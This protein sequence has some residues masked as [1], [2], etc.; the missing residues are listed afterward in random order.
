MSTIQGNQR[1]AL[2]KLAWSQLK[3]PPTVKRGVTAELDGFILA[4]N[5]LN[6][7]DLIV[8]YISEAPAEKNLSQLMQ[9]EMLYLFF[10]E[11]ECGL[12]FDDEDDIW[13]I[14]DN[15]WKPS[16]NLT[17]VKSMVL[18]NFLSVMKLIVAHVK[19]VRLFPPNAEGADHPRLAFL[20]KT[21]AALENRDSIEKIIKES[22][23]FMLREAVFDTNA[24]LFQ[25]QN[26]VL[27][28]ATNT[29][30]RGRPSD[31]SQRA[32]PITV[33]D[34]WL[35][36]PVLFVSE[37]EHQRQDAWNVMWSM[38]ERDGPYHVDD[39][40]DILGDQDSVNFYYLMN[41]HA[42]WLEGRP[43]GKCALFYS[44]R[45]RNS[46]GVNE[47]IISSLWG[48][49]Y[50]PVRPTIFIADRRNE[51]EHTAAELN[52]RGARL[53]WFNETLN[54]PWSNGVF[55]NKNSSDPVVCRGCGAG[56][57]VRYLPTYSFGGGINDPPTWEKKPKGS[58]DDRVMPLYMPNKYL[59]DGES[60]ESPRS[61]KKDVTLEAKVCSEDFALGHLLNLIQIRL[62]AKEDGISLDDIIAQGTP[63]SKHWRQLWMSAWQS[64]NAGLDQNGYSL[65]D[66]VDYHSR[67]YHE[68][69]FQ[70]LEW[71]VAKDKNFDGRAV[72]K[73]GKVLQMINNAGVIGQMLMKVTTSLSRKNVEQKALK[74]ARFDYH[75]YDA[76][77][78]QEFFGDLSRY[79]YPVIDVP[80]MFE[81]AEV[82]LGDLNTVPVV[83]E[84]LGSVGEGLEQAL[85]I[86]N[87]CA[88]EARSVQ[89][90]S[91]SG[92]RNPRSLANAIFL[93]RK[94]GYPV[95]VGGGCITECRESG[96]WAIQR[97][98]MQSDGF[99]LLYQIGAGIQNITRESRS[100]MLEGLCA[101]EIDLVA[102]VFQA[103]LRVLKRCTTQEE[104]DEIAW[105]VLL[106]IEYSATWT[107]QAANYY[108]VDVSVAKKIFRRIHLMGRNKPDEDVEATRSQDVLPCILEL[109][110]AFQ[111]GHRLIQERDDKYKAIWALPKVQSAQNPRLSC[112]GIRLHDEQT[113]M[114]RHVAI[115]TKETPLHTL[116]FVHDSVY[117]LGKNV[118]SLE[119]D[120]QTVAASAMTSY[121]I[122]LA[123]KGIDGKVVAQPLAQSVATPADLPETSRVT[124]ASTPRRRVFSKRIVVTDHLYFVC[125]WKCL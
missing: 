44:K 4:H 8:S 98:Y 26:C 40:F 78:D 107:E 58:E 6:K 72:E 92:E 108:Q 37:T 66:L 110:W 120:F 25:L 11:D 14:F 17:R 62:Q 22:A 67:C 91:V 7:H 19:S 50:V 70:I 118:V 42:R 109:Q 59:D 30:R 60:L 27:D 95:E 124:G 96:I 90:I 48:T 21:V 3:V 18:A 20:K 106:Y 69:K 85:E 1:P 52:R 125:L 88:M 89:D 53:L 36:D 15:F 46:K 38:F 76:L 75:T 34:E 82:L 12:F 39:N 121:G 23:V 105:I 94:S 54:Q 9:A 28:L 35:D 87:L 100:C 73:W 56:R 71:V 86:A 97:H 103:F 84:E 61:F 31:M 102:A 43:T 63:T 49:Y 45:G 68:G 101:G 79:K 13:W 33:K 119:E 112:F 80:S 104:Y 5:G 116:G 74:I 47:K 113:D 24:N 83:S 2:P 117:V 99:G 114:V 55:K 65:E 64:N 10:K 122:R 16:K 29:F 77:F 41:L 115:L 81:E 51:N 93:I 57:V 123:L 32:S 111:T